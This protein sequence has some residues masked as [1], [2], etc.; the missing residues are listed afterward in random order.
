MVISGAATLAFSEDLSWF[1]GNI[2]NTQ[3]DTYT[4]RGS[5]IR[6]SDT[7]DIIEKETV[8]KCTN[9]ETIEEIESSSPNESFN[10]DVRIIQ[11][12]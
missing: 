8:Q 10:S 2:V 6:D 4:I 1:Q 11:E 5:L 7:I 12:L 3:S 9:C